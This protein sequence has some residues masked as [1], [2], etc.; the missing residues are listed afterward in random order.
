MIRKP[1]GISWDEWERIL[2]NIRLYINFYANSNYSLCLN[3]V[4]KG[5]DKYSVLKENIIKGYEAL[6]LYWEIFD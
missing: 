2:D 4:L 1:T 6:K 3:F 5:Q